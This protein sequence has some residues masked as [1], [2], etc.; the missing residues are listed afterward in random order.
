MSPLSARLVAEGIYLMN[1]GT[2]EGLE[3]LTE[4]DLQV[5]FT[6][7]T[8]MRTALCAEMLEGLITILKK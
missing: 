8:S 1:G 3:K 6:V 2:K 5:I 7:Y 4:D